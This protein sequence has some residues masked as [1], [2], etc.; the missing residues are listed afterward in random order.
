MRNCICPEKL[1]MNKYLQLSALTCSHCLKYSRCSETLA[2][3]DGNLT[4]IYLFFVCSTW[5]LPGNGPGRDLGSDPQSHM[6]IV[7]KDG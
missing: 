1:N 2:L 5:A 6:L 3:V 7:K 4:N